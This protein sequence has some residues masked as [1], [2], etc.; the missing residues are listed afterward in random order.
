MRRFTLASCV[1]GL[2][3][4]SPPT[5]GLADV[6]VPPRPVLPQCRVLEGL[7]GTWDMQISTEATETPGKPSAHWSNHARMGGEP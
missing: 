4:L 6:L 2:L 1:L 3:I 5:I 7:V